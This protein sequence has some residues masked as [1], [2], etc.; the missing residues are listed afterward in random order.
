MPRHIA[1]IAC[2]LM[3]AA[4]TAQADGPHCEDWWFARN[5]IFDR[6]GYCFSSP[7][8][9]ALF[10]NSDCTTAEPRLTPEAAAIVAQIRGMERDEACAVDTTRTRLADPGAVEAYRRMEDIPVR[11]IG[12][13][14]CLGYLGAPL[15]L[16]SGARTG[17]PVIGWVE[18]GMDVGFAHFTRNGYDYVTAF[19]KNNSI[20]GA[21]SGWALIGPAPLPCDGYAG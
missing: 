8:G 4:P 11:D 16:H 20:S 14:G 19:P 9:A 7:L 15:A 13:S 1:Y 18:P 12:E 2:A 21:F 3:L 5:L 6:A 10:D 17:A